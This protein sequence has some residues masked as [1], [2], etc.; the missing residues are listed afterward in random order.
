MALAYTLFFGAVELYN[1]LRTEYSSLTKK[2]PGEGRMWGDV[3]ES[4]RHVGRPDLPDLG[5]GSPAMQKVSF[6]MMML[7]IVAI[8]IAVIYRLHDLGRSGWWILVIGLAEGAVDQVVRSPSW[9]PFLTPF[10]ASVFTAIALCSFRGDVGSNTWGPPPWPASVRQSRAMGE[11][12]E[13]DSAESHP[14]G[15]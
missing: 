10:S 13:V 4:L 14:Q 15:P 9:W 11:S 5:F 7:V 6:L 2:Q 8:T 3:L 12:S 1:V